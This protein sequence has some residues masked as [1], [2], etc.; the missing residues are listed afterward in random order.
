MKRLFLI[1]GIAIVL[2]AALSADPSQ[3]ALLNQYCVVC[4]NEQLKTGNLMLDKL[5][6]E[7]VGP[8]AEV[9][10]KVVRKLRAGLM[11]PAGMPRPDRTAV[12]AFLTSLDA[13]L[14]RAASERP[15]PGAP[16]LH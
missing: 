8:D 12:A 7:H 1:C 6:V 3:R 13:S 11:P 16:A 2:A 14:D 5:D 4:H 15:N 9:W 10:E